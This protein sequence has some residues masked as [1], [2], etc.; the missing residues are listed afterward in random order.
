[1]PDH[2]GTWHGLAWTCILTGD[3]VRANEA[4]ECSM[5]LDRNFADN[6]GTKAV[7]E[8]MLGR[9][10]E[11]ELSTRK[12]LKLNPAAPS[13]LYARSL[14]QD[15]AGDGAAADATVEKILGTMRA[16]NGASLLEMYKNRPRKAGSGPRP[17]AS[18]LH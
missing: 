1:M 3:L 2:Q 6:H 18:K 14:L 8:F 9:R 7:L 12:A 11:A 5:Q 17:P 15:A 13:A 4:I 16:P 10:T